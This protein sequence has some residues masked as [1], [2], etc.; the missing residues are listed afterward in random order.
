MKPSLPKPGNAIRLK[1]GTKQDYRPDFGGAI[2]FD[3][4]FGF[5]GKDGDFLKL[6]IES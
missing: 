1:M 4:D 6:N 2:D 3:R 5:F